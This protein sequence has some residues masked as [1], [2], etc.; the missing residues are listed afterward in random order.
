MRTVV[1]WF[2]SLF[3]S[4]IP[5]AFVG[6]IIVFLACVFD[7]QGEH[8]PPAHSDAPLQAEA[9]A[10]K[11]AL[12]V[13]DTDALAKHSPGKHAHGDAD[14]RHHHATPRRSRFHSHVR[15]RPLEFDFG[16]LIGSARRNGSTWW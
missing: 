13:A 5:F 16:F 14:S 7:A 6:A 9:A 3:A 1:I 15:H 4:A 12:A 10:P 2:S 11:L 8:A